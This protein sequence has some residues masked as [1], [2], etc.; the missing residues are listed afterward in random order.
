MSLNKWGRQIN[1]PV[2]VEIL[3][4]ATLAMAQSTIQNAITKAGLSRADL[5]RKMDRPR[6]FISL[7]L[8]GNHNL[9]IRTM[10]KALAA[11]G[12]EIRFAC[13]PITW[14]WKT[15]ISTHDV[16]KAGVAAPNEDQVPAQAGTT[17][18]IGNQLTGIVVPTWAIQTGAC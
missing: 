10:A 6:S 13:A 9:T 11:C 12:C 5:A 1:S 4:E 2:D 7:M 8:S 18:P 14:S 15:N 3:E 17:M 16:E